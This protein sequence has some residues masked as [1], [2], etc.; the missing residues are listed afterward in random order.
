MF[1]NTLNDQYL[2]K[3]QKIRSGENK[4][5]LIK[6]SPHKDVSTQ[7]VSIWLVQV[8]TLAGTDTST[9]TGHSKRAT[10]KAKALGVPTKEI[11]KRGYCWSRS[12]TFQ[13]YYQNEMIE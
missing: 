6:I 11:L 3:T 13:K 1:I 2:E 8:L 5:L 4:L 10:S 9:F 12:Y 7:T